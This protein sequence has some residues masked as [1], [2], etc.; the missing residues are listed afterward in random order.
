M[1]TPADSPTQLILGVVTF[2][3]GLLSVL[4]DFYTDFICKTAVEAI[5]FVARCVDLLCIGVRADLRHTSKDTD[6]GFFN[7]N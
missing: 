7:V 1:F 2:E 5:P 6:H 4:I 3:E